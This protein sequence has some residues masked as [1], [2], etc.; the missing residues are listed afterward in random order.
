MD[1]VSKQVSLVHYVPSSESFQAY[2]DGN[3]FK[4]PSLLPYEGDPRVKLASLI[5]LRRSTLRNAHLA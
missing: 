4:F 2:L 5:H 3:S 1:I